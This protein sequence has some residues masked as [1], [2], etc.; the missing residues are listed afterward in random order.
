MYSIGKFSKLIGK[1]SKT[2]RVWE[3]NGTLIPAYKTIGNHR[4]Y[5]DEQLNFMLNKPGNKPINIGYARVSSKKQNDDLKR[6]EDLI[7]NYLINKSTPF[8]IIS[9][10]GSGIN[11][12]KKGFNEIIKMINSKEIDTLVVL[13]KDRLVRFGFEIIENLCKLNNV[14]LEII[15]NDDTKTSEEEM[16]EDILNIIHVFSCKM[17]G[18]RSHINKKI[19][20]KLNDSCL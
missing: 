19:I 8:K 1:T 3:S 5:S 16:I 4:M 18:K 13:Y 2:L 6:Q 10:V 17:N 15:N 14:K 11:Y 20:D 7:E 12:N 9:D